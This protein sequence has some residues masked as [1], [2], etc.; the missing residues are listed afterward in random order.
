M[1]ALSYL[2]EYEAT[3]SEI[4]TY[5]PVVIPGLLQT[6]EHM[7]ALFRDVGIPLSR[8]GIERAVE[9]RLERQARVERENNADLHFI[10]DEAVVRRPVG[11]PQVHKRQLEKIRT[12]A[13][14]SVKSFRVV[15]LSAGSYPGLAGPFTIYEFGEDVRPPLACVGGRAGTLFM[16][17]ADNIRQCRAAFDAMHDVALTREALVRL[18]DEVMREL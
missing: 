12:A 4:R 6:E 8:D 15:P 14:S 11:G 7:R 3:A 17:D 18:L 13:E 16:E 5:E 2:R 10:V 1:P 9:I